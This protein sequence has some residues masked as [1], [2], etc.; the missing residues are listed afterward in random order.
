MKERDG[1]IRRNRAVAVFDASDEIRF[2]VD[3]AF[4][5][6]LLKPTRERFRR[7]L[8]LTAED[9]NFSSRSADLICLLEWLQQGQHRKVFENC[10]DRWCDWRLSPRF[11]RIQGIAAAELGLQEEAELAKFQ[12]QSCLQGILDTGKGTGPSPFQVM[13]ACDEPEVLTA[14]GSERRGQ[15][16]VSRGTRLLD[17]IT[18][19]DQ[20]EIWFEVAEISMTQG[21]VEAL[22]RN[23]FPRELARF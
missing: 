13:F 21:A 11:H 2:M 7:V 12:F 20:Q 4:E 16:I 19:R 14:L 3:D 10:V 23:E 15:R 22:A 5:A 1:F 6:F 18:C 9:P 17:V 8:R